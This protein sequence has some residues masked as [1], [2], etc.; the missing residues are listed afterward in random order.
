MY[1]DLEE[2]M[3]S[4]AE[5]ANF[6]PWLDEMTHM[7]YRKHALDKIIVG[8]PEVKNGQINF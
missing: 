5:L 4:K 7:L 3:I 8:P 2:E 1:A 6:S